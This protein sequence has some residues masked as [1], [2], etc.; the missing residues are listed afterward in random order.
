MS[1]SGSFGVNSTKVYGNSTTGPAIV[2]HAVGDL[3]VDRRGLW[4]C[5]LFNT[6]VTAYDLVVFG[7][8]VGQTTALATAGSATTTLV[9]TGPAMGGV[10]QAAF[11]SGD[12]GWVWIGQGGGLGLGVKVRV[13]ISCALGVKL[14]T[15]ATAGCADDS[16]TAGLIAGLS[17][18]AA[19]PGSGTAAIE[20]SSPIIIG[21]NLNAA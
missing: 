15:T 4:R 3:G 5:C 13:L 17:I 10:A 21:Y 9:S 19:E 20:C 14:Y 18:T 11:A 8:T 6:A 12:Y 1:G 7:T 16:S 2:E